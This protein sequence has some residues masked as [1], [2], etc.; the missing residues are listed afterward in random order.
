MNIPARYR[1]GYLGDIGTF[2]PYGPP[3]FAASFEP[4]LGD[5]RYTF[6]RTQ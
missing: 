3:D 5:G 2:P 6:R 4:N 1:T